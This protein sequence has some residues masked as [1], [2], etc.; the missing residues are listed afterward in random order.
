MWAPLTYEFFSARSEGEIAEPR[1]VRNKAL[2]VGI[3]IVTI[4]GLCRSFASLSEWG[5]CPMGV[6]AKI[7][8]HKPSAFAETHC[9]RRSLDL[10]RMWHDKIEA[11]MVAQAGRFS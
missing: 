9:R 7:Q 2:T 1:I 10:L 6:V 5:E 4:Q 11:W 3:P 8:G